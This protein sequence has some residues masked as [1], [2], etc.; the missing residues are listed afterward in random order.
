M[1]ES[2]PETEEHKD[3]KEKKTKKKWSVKRELLKL[4]IFFGCF[5]L[6]FSPMNTY[7]ANFILFHPYSKM[8]I[9]LPTMDL[10][11]DKFNAKWNILT[12]DA[13]DGS[14]LSAWYWEIPNP[15]GTILVSHGNAG[16]LSHRV[17]LLAPMM[18]SG[19]SVFLYDY[20]GYGESEGQS[21]DRTIVEDGFTAYDYMTRKLH[22]KPSDIVLYGESL[23]C[24][25]STEILEKRQARAVVL[26]SC[27]ASVV[28]AARDKFLWTA[29]YP[30]YLFP[31]RH[32]D[33]V[34]AY[35][36]PHP[37]LLLLHGEKDF[38]LPAAY[39]KKVYEKAIE[40]KTLYLV[41]GC[42][43]NDFY[44]NDAASAIAGFQGFLSKLDAPR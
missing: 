36:R 41:K 22:I 7:F 5:A 14:K 28:D 1:V 3:D 33:N 21:D 24:A 38:I 23:G 2:Q 31:Q 26:Q 16:N 6:F 12:L 27:F 10:L 44:M 39:A 15:K 30:D 40:P 17:H 37:P 18:G 19:Y 29:I 4:T 32:L 20:R 43:H 25:V 8:E 9:H 35:T 13:R 34:T 42:G 11:R